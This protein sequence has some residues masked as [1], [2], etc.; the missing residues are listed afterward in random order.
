MPRPT[1]QAPSKPRLPICE[2]SWR[3]SKRQAM[4]LVPPAATPRQAQRTERP[5]L[6]PLLKPAMAL[7]QS[8]SRSSGNS[9]R[10]HEKASRTLH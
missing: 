7:P 8:Q 9:C 6:P 4:P 1:L 2:P 5:L 3:H 10:R